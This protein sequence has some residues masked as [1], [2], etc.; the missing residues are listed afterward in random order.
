MLFYYSRVMTNYQKLDYSIIKVEGEDAS[1][2]LQSIITNDIE[3]KGT[4]YSLM[5]TPQGKFLFDFFITYRDDGFFIEIHTSQLEAFMTRLKLYRLRS[6]VLISYLAEYGVIYSRMSVDLPKLYEYKDPR[7]PAL[8]IRTVMAVNEIS[9]NEDIYSQDKYTYSIPEGYCELI[10]DKSMPLEYGIEHLNAISFTK[11]CYVGQEVISRTK[12]QGV[13]RK[14]VF[15][16]IASDDLSAVAAG[17][18]IMI[19]NNKI[20]IFC[21]AYKSMGIGLVRL[22][23]YEVMKD[24]GAVMLGGIKVEI[25]HRNFKR[26]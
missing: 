16:I 23:N 25:N 22:E 7:H 1:R 18:D 20:G 14:G 15:K 5:L 17:S 8:G 13:I 4:I 24:Q 6:K 9:Q 12:Y 2:F 26:V 11:G 21:S 3:A 10:Q 19:N